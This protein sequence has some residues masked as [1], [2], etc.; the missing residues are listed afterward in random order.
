[1]ARTNIVPTV[2]DDAGVSPAP[3]VGTADGLMFSNNGDELVVLK[4]NGAGSHT[5]TLPTPATR[6]DLAV[7]DRTVVLAAGATRYVG[8]LT[9][10]LYNQISGV[11]MGKVYINIDA[12]PGDVTAVVLRQPD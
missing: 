8:P 5:V 3:T 4:N 10:S 12:T 1:M 11:D 9:P 6:D 2:M 7:G